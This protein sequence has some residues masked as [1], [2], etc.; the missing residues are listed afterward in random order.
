MYIITLK[1]NFAEV[2][3]I[4]RWRAITSRDLKYY[5]LKR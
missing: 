2:L 1:Y 3:F 4:N 5:R